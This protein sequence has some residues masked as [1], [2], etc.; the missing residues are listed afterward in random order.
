MQIDELFRHYADP[1]ELAVA[2]V[3]VYGA[4]NE[5]LT[6]AAERWVARFGDVSAR[7]Y[8]EQQLLAE[9]IDAAVW[10]L[11]QTLL[12]AAVPLGFDPFRALVLKARK[13]FT[14][15]DFPEVKRVQWDPVLLDVTVSLASSRHEFA[16]W[17]EILLGVVRRRSDQYVFHLAAHLSD[18][19]PDLAYE[20]LDEAFRRPE[21]APQSQY[22]RRPMGLLRAYGLEK[23]FDPYGWIA[24]SRFGSVP[25]ASLGERD[26]RLIE[27]IT[28]T[29]YLDDYFELAFAILHGG[30]EVPEGVLRAAKGALNSAEPRTRLRG[31]AFLA[32]FDDTREEAIEVLA[33]WDEWVAALPDRPRDGALAAF[34]PPHGYE[35]AH[36]VTVYGHGLFHGQ[37]WGREKQ[38]ERLHRLVGPMLRGKRWSIEPWRAMLG[39]PLLSRESPRGAELDARVRDVIAEYLFRLAKDEDEPL[40]RR[41]AAITAIARAQAG[42]FARDLGKFRRHAALRE[43]AQQ[44]QQYLREVNRVGDLAVDVA[45]DLSMRGFL[46]GAS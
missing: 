28:P 2:L 35:L 23:V 29:Q 7:A 4:R 25:S 16:R 10:R 42:S 12:D 3:K 24:L 41:R 44:A 33:R 36:N 27:R 40:D 22:F 26:L 43:V 39:P 21:P 30:R 14:P 45:L 15:P 1:Y 18:E 31:V 32:R 38:R 9:D 46:E 11:L 34:G 13:E 8:R 5:S 19:M 17:R 37:G 20:L 6:Q